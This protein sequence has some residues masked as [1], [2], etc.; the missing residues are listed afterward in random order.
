M[1]CNTIFISRGDVLR[2]GERKSC[3][4][5]RFTGHN[6]IQ[7]KTFNYLTALENTNK[8]STDRTFI[9]K[10]QC[11]CGTIKEVSRKNL[12]TGDVKSCGCLNKENGEKIKINMIGKTFNY[13]TVLYELPK[14]GE[15]NKRIYYHCKCKCGNECDVDGISLRNGNTKSCG[16]YKLERISEIKTKDLVGQTFGLLTVKERYHEPS[17]DGRVQWICECACGNTKIISSHQ[18]LSYGTISCGCAN[19]YGEAAI[20]KILNDNNINFIYN[21]QYY[22]DLVS[23]NNV[24]LRYDFIILQDNIP[25]RLIEFDGPQ[26]EKPYEY[27]GGD[28][29]FQKIKYN[30]KLKNEYAYKHNIPLVRIPYKERD[31][32]TL[33]LIMGDKYLIK[34]NKNV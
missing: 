21:K 27:F 24:P 17:T 31:N 25:I 20:I 16:C 2:N 19:S 10:C 28:I 4:S 30:D 33:D 29:Y 11:K 32:I 13:L 26:H 14:R 15:S 5:H 18:L 23:E 6:D 7:G 1:I 22:E 9:W 34:E 3:G 12:V 8:I